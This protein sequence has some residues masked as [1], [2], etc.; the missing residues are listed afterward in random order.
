M[1]RRR[2]VPSL[3]DYKEKYGLAE[4]F[5]VHLRPRN[6]SVIENAEPESYEDMVTELSMATGL[7]KSETKAL[8]K[9]FGDLILRETVIN[10]AFR[11]PGIFEIR[12]KFYKPPAS[13]STEMNAVIQ[14]PPR[15]KLS[16]E[17]SPA[18]INAYDWARKY[19]LFKTFDTNADNYL[20]NFIVEGNIS[21]EEFAERKA[22]GEFK[23]VS[24]DKTIHLVSKK[25]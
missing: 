3:S 19:E 15:M 25:K 4:R 7:R 16:I 5:I 11:L 17:L 18:I 22:R 13:H 14:Y 23:G 9:A 2:K 21:A 20:K 8:L 12:S 24:P 6:T 10:G 1:A